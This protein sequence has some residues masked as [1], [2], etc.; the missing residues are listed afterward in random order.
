M[1]EFIE[2]AGRQ[3]GILYSLAHLF[4]NGFILKT[5]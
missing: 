4:S 2:L 3:A 1:K 5:A